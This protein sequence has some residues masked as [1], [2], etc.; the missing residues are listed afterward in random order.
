MIHDISL[1]PRR[2]GDYSET[3]YL[4]QRKKQSFD[5]RQNLARDRTG[6]IVTHDISLQPRRRGDSIET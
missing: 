6:T 2:R 1:Q 5:P 3:C 4:Q